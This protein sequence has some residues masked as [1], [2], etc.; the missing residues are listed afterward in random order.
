MKQMVAV[1]LGLAL[2]AAPA[3]AGRFDGPTWSMRWVP[4]E[5]SKP[6]VM[7][8]TTMTP[9]LRVE[10]ETYLACIQREAK[11]DLEY[12]TEAIRQGLRDEA[13]DIDRQIILLR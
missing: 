2:A 13:S 1:A 4:S 12:A 6:L 5:C 9:A 8:H 3:A 11:K 10:I 7:F